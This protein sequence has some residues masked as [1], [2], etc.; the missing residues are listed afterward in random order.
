[1]SRPDDEIRIL[2]QI[3]SICSTYVQSLKAGTSGSAADS[4][5]Q[6]LVQHPDIPRRELLQ[7]LLID[8]RDYRTRIGAPSL[9]TELK[10]RFPHDADLIERVF[11][12]QTHAP[13]PQPDFLSFNI[14]GYEIYNPV[15]E[16]TYGKVYHAFDVARRR[17]V[18]IKITKQ[19]STAN[20]RELQRFKS[21]IEAL[22]QLRHPGIVQIHD[23][24]VS[25]EQHYYVMDY[26]ESGS[27]GD[28]ISRA[29]NTLSGKRSRP[30]TTRPIAADDTTDNTPPATDPAPSRSPV[31]TP[32]RSTAITYPDD[33]FLAAFGQRPSPAAARQA[34]AAIVQIGIQVAEAMQY[35]H[36]HD[37]VHRDLKPNNLLMD[38]RGRVYV[39]DFG[40][41]QVNDTPHQTL[42]GE[43]IGTLAYMAPEQMQGSRLL[44]DSRS[45][46]FSL[47]A[48]LYELLAL[49]RVRDGA[50]NDVVRRQ[51]LFETA[52]PLRRRN[53]AVPRDLENIIHHAISYRPE[54]R[55]QTMQ[56]FAEDLQRYHSLQPVLAKPTGPLKRFALWVEREQKLAVALASS[57]CLLL[58]IL[59]LLL[60]RENKGRRDS[61][62][63]AER[64]S[65]EKAQI[66][67][68]LNKSE[69][70]RLVTASLL[71][72]SR[73]Q[74]PALA[75]LLAD[76]ATKYAPLPEASEASIIALRRNHEIRSWKPRDA[77]TLEAGMTVH[78]SGTRVV[79][80]ASPRAI[81]AGKVYEAVE[82]SITTGKLLRTY[83]AEGTI[84]AAL[85]DHSGEFLA[86]MDAIAIQ[87]KER[88]RIELCNLFASVWDGNSG[89]LL[90][91]RSVGTA[92]SCDDLLKHQSAWPLLFTANAS[93][94]RSLITRNGSQ[95]CRWAIPNG[96]ASP[97]SSEPLPESAII[98]TASAAF[99]DTDPAEAGLAVLFDT[100]MVKT[101]DAGS[102]NLRWTQT[103]GPPQPTFRCPPVALLRN[104]SLLFATANTLC[105]TNDRGVPIPEAT[106]PCDQ[107]W[108]T[109]DGNAALFAFADVPYQIL[110]SNGHT[111]RTSHTRPRTH[112]ATAAGSGTQIF[113]AVTGSDHILYSLSDSEP[114]FKIRSIKPSSQTAPTVHAT[115]VTS[116]TLLILQEDGT[117]SLTSAEPL[118]NQHTLTHDLEH[119]STSPHKY[120]VSTDSKLV[121]FQN[122]HRPRAFIFTSRDLS[123][124]RSLSGYMLSQHPLSDFLP[125]S[126]DDRHVQLTTL[127]H[128][129]TTT[130]DLPLP[131]TPAEILLKQT[132]GNLLCRSEQ[133]EIISFNPASGA[134][135]TITPASPQAP[136][137]A[138]NSTQHLCAIS[139]DKS[140]EILLLIQQV[141]HSIELPP[142]ITVRCMAFNADGDRL[143]TLT[144]A[145]SLLTWKIDTAGTTGPPETTELPPNSCNALSL[146]PDG[147]QFVVWNNQPE[148]TLIARGTLNDLP[149]ESIIPETITAA[150]WLDNGELLLGTTRGLYKWPPDKPPQ[151]T[152]V[153]SPVRSL[154]STPNGVVAVETAR[155]TPPPATDVIGSGS[156][157]SQAT[158]K[159]VLRSPDTLQVLTQHTLPGYFSDATL[160]ADKSFVAINSFISESRISELQ[161]RRSVPIGNPGSGGVC[162]QQFLPNT[163]TLLT[164][165]SSGTGHL[166]NYDTKTEE[167]FE[168]STEPLQW[169]MLSS[170]GS[171]I[172][173][174]SF[175]NDIIIC[176]V[177][178]PHKTRTVKMPQ[179]FSPAHLY[180]L[181]PDGNTI[182]RHSEDGK[183]QFW[184]LQDSA[185]L[186]VDT[187]LSVQ[188]AIW[189]GSN[190]LL[191]FAHNADNT[192]TACFLRPD[193]GVRLPF[194]MTFAQKIASVWS[195]PQA[196]KHI[197][198][199]QDGTSQLLSMQADALKCELNF[200]S[201]FN[202]SYRIDLRDD[203]PHIASLERDRTRIFNSQQKTFDISIPTTNSVPFFTYWYGEHPDLMSRMLATDATAI[204]H[205]EK[206]LEHWPVG[207]LKLELPRSLTTEEKALYHVK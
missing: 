163:H 51:A 184:H 86:T 42:P 1:M 8:D 143:V 133:H 136:A 165:T 27:L 142:G 164:V 108:L 59:A 45:D 147:Q 128:T 96:E 21:E 114:D 6:L 91:R 73:N 106:Y 14:P 84:I 178:P 157:Y 148:G 13:Q 179:P 78:P 52:V 99:A 77:N 194:K 23:S 167:P 60:A 201:I 3:D 98:A 46:V 32:V 79:T 177:S 140:S 53:P 120:T 55:Y 103:F 156:P 186:T 146:S 5:E 29:K 138:V 181:S 10:V 154:F 134:A 205:S 116:S 76:A 22:S 50:S 15:A 31:A 204:I 198:R 158:H 168:L 139:R 36:D 48:T 155:A 189:V 95:L 141:Q 49:T 57:F 75:L 119:I 153:D 18:A 19:R 109:Q 183:L 17:F 110:Y 80:T 70:S 34:T 2:L 38:D 105:L 173:A 87:P 130:P 41:A 115:Y 9:L 64:E 137:T 124:S 188:K 111:A 72:S 126:T 113:T 47:G 174:F 171:T 122:S 193:S 176:G 40:M 117:L 196:K 7:Q 37:I 54:D 97:F 169:V 191:A 150:A 151:P 16:G 61:E 102:G 43:E 89:D 88:T 195:S 44:I 11:S 144:N 129:A 131:F 83:K 125:L 56:A 26:I 24:G 20:T 160:S 101:F 30:E 190:K 197:V 90:F 82:S 172:V 28:L 187:N 127:S 159:L 152:A 92:V 121:A 74:D 104:G 170:T 68:Q 162:L 192:T 107:Y 81:R 123:I 118:S 180:A 66:Q 132:N 182:S 12:A 202:T 166:F 100:G 149:R 112:Y 93:K 203:S 175:T 145:N 71:L 33:A 206:T 35:V 58:I 39:A 63:A 199:F 85:W 4:I 135:I 200:G 25:G 65:K 69:A 161:Q 62:R 67:A 94:T 185:F 207:T